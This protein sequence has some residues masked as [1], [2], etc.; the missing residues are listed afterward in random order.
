LSGSLEAPRD[1][2]ANRFHRALEGFELNYIFTYASRLP[3]N[4]LLG[5][6]RNNDTNFNDRPFGVGRNTGRGF[7]FASLDLRVSRRF[8]FTERLKLEALIEG[9]NVFNRAN[10]QIPNNTFGTGLLPRTTFGLPTAASDPRQIQFGLR[11]SY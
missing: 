8:N 11:F 10:L 2:Y 3:F 9:F 7:D 5:S 6:D 1:E 4:I